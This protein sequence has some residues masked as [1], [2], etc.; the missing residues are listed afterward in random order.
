M[1]TRSVLNRDKKILQRSSHKDFESYTDT[2]QRVCAVSPTRVYTGTEMIG[3]AQMHKSN[4]VPI[5]NKQ[6]A[7]D[8]SKMRR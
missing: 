2:S 4:A 1:S 8:I 6:S 3:I 7:V 5:F